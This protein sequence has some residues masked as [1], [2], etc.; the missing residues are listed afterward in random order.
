MFS[1]TCIEEFSNF[2]E[3]EMENSSPIYRS[4]W[5]GAGSVAAVF[6]VQMVVEYRSP[7]PTAAL[8]GPPQMS[9]RRCLSTGQCNTSCF[10]QL[11]TGDQFNA[12][13][14]KQTL[15]ENATCKMLLESL[16]CVA[17]HLVSECVCIS[18]LHFLFK[19]MHV[20]TP[21]PL[22]MKSLLHQSPLLHAVKSLNMNWQAVVLPTVPGAQA[23]PA[24][25]I[26]PLSFIHLNLKVS[27]KN[28]YSLKWWNINFSGDI[29]IF[30]LKLQFSFYTFLFI[31]F[32]SSQNE[33]VFSNLS[34]G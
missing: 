33:I 13:Q 7:H 9:R 4:G 6:G 3:M 23:L 29:Q 30:W 31:L 5:P 28:L 12:A 8:T 34:K 2:N 18:I 21:E 25:Q 32:F 11:V 20:F 24:S 10:R 17:L 26:P 15:F 27:E 1:V 14:L 22:R 19:N 16:L